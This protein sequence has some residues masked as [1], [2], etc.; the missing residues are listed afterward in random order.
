M[1]AVLEQTPMT[2]AIDAV[3]RR[4]ILAT[5]AGLP[6]VERPYHQIA[7]EL[8]LSPGEVMARMEQMLKT[9]VIRRIGAVPNHYKLGFK[10]NGM[11][12]WDVPDS[13]VRRLGQLIGALEFVSHCYHR[14]RHPP[15]WPYNLF[16][17]VHGHDRAEVMQQVQRIA[18]LLGDAVHGHDVLFST[19]ILKKTGMRLLAE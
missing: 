6:R 19:R 8:G 14:P 10:G 7:A 12:V 13:D 3:D 17:M 15:Y 4:I 1:A 2:D 11:S 9:G 5:Q 16:A 18:D